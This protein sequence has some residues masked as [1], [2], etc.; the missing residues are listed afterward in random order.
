MAVGLAAVAALVSG[1]DDPPSQAGGEGPARVTLVSPNGSEGAALFELPA[2]GVLAVRAPVG[3][4]IEAQTG[5]ARQ[6]AVVLSQPGPIVLEL[7][8]AD[9][10]E[11]PDVRVLEVSGPEDQARALTGYRV[12]VEVPR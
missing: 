3:A 4:L 2:A 10:T 1:C 9:Q 5:G 7:T 8:V 6:V 11:L 12:Q